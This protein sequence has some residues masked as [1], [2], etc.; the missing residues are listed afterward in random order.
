MRLGE[1]IVIKIMAK[2]T[3]RKN[4]THKGLLPQILHGLETMLGPFFV[5]PIP[6]LDV[7]F[8]VASL[9]LHQ[10]VIDFLHS[11]SEDRLRLLIVCN[12]YS[13]IEFY[14]YLVVYVHTVYIHA[15]ACT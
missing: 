4:E 10:S 13:E 12:S 15:H 7:T 6:I 11:T 8:C 1:S 14:Y 9:M 2:S 5:H 3:E